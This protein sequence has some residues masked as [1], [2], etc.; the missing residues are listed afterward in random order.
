MSRDGDSFWNK[1]GPEN[2]LF[3]SIGLHMLLKAQIVFLK[4][5]PSL[6]C[7]LNLFRWKLGGPKKVFYKGGGGFEL[8]GPNN[9]VKLS[10]K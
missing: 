1:F 5:T 4:A 10:V 2:L 3:V 9:N 6:L 7:V 8:G